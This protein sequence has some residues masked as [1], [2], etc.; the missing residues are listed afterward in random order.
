MPLL[1]AVGLLAATLLAGVLLGVAGLLRRPFRAPRWQP[2]LPA[3]LA[4]RAI[5][6]LCVLATTA[7]VVAVRQPDRLGGLA[8]GA[9]AGLGLGA[10]SGATTRFEIG[11]RPIGHRPHRIFVVIL[12]LA[13]LARIAGEWWGGRVATVDMASAVP[14]LVGLLIGY[15]LAQALVVRARARK[16]WLRECGS[17]TA[18]SE[19]RMHR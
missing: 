18:Q 2:V 12:A 1:I 10:L 16:L 14:V 19:R 4:L 15:P 3:I 13:V 11:R 5:A 7:A 9:L 6:L 17:S 8:L